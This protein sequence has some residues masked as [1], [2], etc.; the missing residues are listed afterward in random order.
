MRTTEELRRQGLEA[1]RSP[2]MIG[3]LK[4]ALLLLVFV[5]IY[6]RLREAFAGFRFAD[7]RIHWLLLAG[8][9]LVFEL[10]LLSGAALWQVLTSRAGIAVA[11]GH[12]TAIWLVSIMGKY[13]PGKA[14][15]W[16]IRYAYYRRE[17]SAFSA[18][19]ILRCFLLEYLAGIAAGG[20][21]IL[22][23]VTGGEALSVSPH[24]RAA[25][26]ALLA[27][28]LL[29]IFFNHS[30]IRGLF[31]RVAERAGFRQAGHFEIPITDFSLALAWSLAN[32][33]ILGFAVFLMA[34]ALRPELTV[35]DLLYVSATY[36]FAGI[37]GFLAF[38]APSGI[39]VRE[40][41]FIEAA[42][43][44]M[45]VEEAALL[46]ALARLTST[47]GE[48]LA[49]GAGWLLV[50]G[51]RCTPEDVASAKERPPPTAPRS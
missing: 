25:A 5:F 11:T 24:F 44:L 21:F 34:K 19:G 16:G 10:Y 12:A 26:A 2:A 51:V 42:A 50:P 30:M 48:V 28:L 29:P 23:A 35:G 45:P 37:V 13:V 31:I 40:A 8:S 7:L 14:L 4:S 41:V 18:L 49:A 36:A 27:I 22:L 6:L 3:L 20:A 15:L 46:A 47:V 17:S 43:Q 9:L 38:F 33:N 1:L 32:W 39:G